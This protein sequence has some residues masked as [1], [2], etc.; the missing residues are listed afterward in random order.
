[1]HAGRLSSS[2][3]SNI[4]KHL[5]TC[6]Q[7]ISAWALPPGSEYRMQACV[8][9]ARREAPPE[10]THFNCIVSRHVSALHAGKLRPSYLILTV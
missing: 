7:E 5:S 8:N 3:P 10:P 6:M 1:M 9:I 2:L 4:S